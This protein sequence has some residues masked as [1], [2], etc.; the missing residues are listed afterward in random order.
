MEGMKKWTIITLKLQITYKKK[1]SNIV[2][3]TIPVDIKTTDLKNDLNDI[4]NEYII[5]VED[6]SPVDKVELLNRTDNIQEVN[7]KLKPLNKIRMKQSGVGIYD[8]YDKQEWDTNTGRCVF[9]YI[10]HKYGNIDGFKKVCNYESLCK[11]F[12]EIDDNE[13]NNCN[14]L[15]K[16]GVNTNEI[17]RFCDKFDIP[18]Y[19]VDEIENTF[20]QYIPSNR[21]KKCPALIYRLSNT[22]FYP[23][24]DNDKI[25]SIVKITSMINNINS[26]MIETYKPKE[27]ADKIDDDIKDKLENVVFVDDINTTLLGML[28]DG[29]IP[30]KIKLNDKQLVSFYIGKIKLKILI[31][32]KEKKQ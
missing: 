24:N 18:M 8:G 11:I 15:L 7:N 20:T 12:Y 26:D 19:A 1:Y 9:D 17:K 25:K 21:N 31:W 28:N 16:I 4:V 2:F 3:R 27:E 10:I 29:K 5:L 6:E 22:H 23:I 14:E 32:L 13:V 30:D